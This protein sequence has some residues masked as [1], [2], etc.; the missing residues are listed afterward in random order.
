MSHTIKQPIRKV[1]PT[2]ER[3]LKRK[4]SKTEQLL[5]DRH[6]IECCWNMGSMWE[7]VR[8]LERNVRADCAGKFW[9]SV[10]HTA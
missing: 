3:Y 7:A 6:L 9:Q 10:S 4:N 8:H 1:F 5:E 2:S